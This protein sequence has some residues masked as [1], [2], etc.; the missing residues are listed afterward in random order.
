MVKYKHMI[1]IQKLVKNKFVIVMASFAGL[2][3]LLLSPAKVDA[4]TL[5]VSSGCTL[6]E[7]I[8]AVNSG[9]DA[10]GCVKTGA[11]YGTNDTINI[12]AG[13]IASSDDLPNITKSVVI[14]GAGIDQTTVDMNQ[15]VGFEAIISSNKNTHNLTIKNLAIVDADTLA[16]NVDSILTLRLEN[17]E[18]SQSDRAIRIQ[19]TQNVVIRNIDVH[20]NQGGTSSESVGV[21]TDLGTAIA[22]STPNMD[23]DGAKIYGNSGNSVGIYVSPSSFRAESNDQDLLDDAIVKIHNSVVRNNQARSSAGILI[24]QS[25]GPISPTAVDLSVESTTVSNNT[26]VVTDPQVVTGSQYL[27]VLSGFMVAGVLKSTQHFKNV[28]VAYNTVNNPAPDN[29]NSVAG[30]LGSLGVTGS[31]LDIINT[32]VVANTVTQPASNI[33]LPA[34]FATKIGLDDTYQPNA[35]EA[36]STATNVLVSQNKFNGQPYSCANNIDTSLFLGIDEVI[37]LTPTN[38]GHNMSDDKNCTGYAY[39]TGLYKTLEHQVKDNGGPVPTI[40]LLPGSPAINGGGKVLGISTDARGVKRSGY[41]SVGAYQGV[42]LASSTDK[43]DGSLAKTG[44]AIVSSVVLGGILL[45]AMTYTYID[46]RRHRKPLVEADPYA[47]QTYTYQH[48]IRTVTIPLLR[49]RVH[50][51]FSPRPKGLSKF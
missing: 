42:L 46:Y 43:E 48:H 12:P 45:L 23:I 13:T 15:N 51:S 39:E 36:G 49:Y 27:P 32:S 10:D 28:T 41:Y 30:F 31:V 26:V 21:I 1:P 17:I 50:I 38:L 34:F 3:I 25:G 11:V 35:A 29:R 37:D 18:V 33:S 6:S 22:D 19:T 16:I 40:K 44:V 7:S 14:D 47:R 5:S 8:T 9:A 20:N 4:A 24:L 2:C